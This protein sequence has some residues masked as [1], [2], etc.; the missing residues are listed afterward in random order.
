MIKLK[1]KNIF[2]HKLNM[3]FVEEEQSYLDEF[4]E[5][6]DKTAIYPVQR[7]RKIKA[8]RVLYFNIIYKCYKKIFILY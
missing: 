4:L 5:L 7:G 1:F 6:C 2:I 8:R 3:F